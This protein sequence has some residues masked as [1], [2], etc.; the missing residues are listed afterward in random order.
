MLIPERDG[1]PDAARL[2][3]RAASIENQDA[4]LDLIGYKRASDF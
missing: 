1:V 4:S 3:S 2:L